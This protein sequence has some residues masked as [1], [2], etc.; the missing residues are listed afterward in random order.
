MTETEIPFPPL[1]IS[2]S[3]RHFFSPYRWS[4]ASPS[5]LSPQKLER[6]C[7]LTPCGFFPLLSPLL[8]FIITALVQASNI[9]PLN[10][11]S[12]PSPNSLHPTAHLGPSLPSLC[13][14]CLT[15]AHFHLASYPL[16]HLQGFSV[17]AHRRLKT[18]SSF[19]VGAGSPPPTSPE[20]FFPRAPCLSLSSHSSPIF[21]H[22]QQLCPSK[23]VPRTDDQSADR[24]WLGTSCFL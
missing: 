6:A 24:Q 16:E 18:T 23:G 10:G 20:T 9:C 1:L 7:G 13:A 2:G 11:P 17:M 14:A 15:Q 8:W 19:T 21:L 5:A 4:L 12:L 22:C 3:S